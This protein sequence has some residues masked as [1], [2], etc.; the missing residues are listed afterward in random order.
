M[1]TLTQQA[2]DALDL[3]TYAEYMIDFVAEAQTDDHRVIAAEQ[4]GDGILITI[5]TYGRKRTETRMSFE[6]DGRVNRVGGNASVAKMLTDTVE[7]YRERCASY[8]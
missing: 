6:A 8:C 5:L 2:G 7:T 4:D 3:T 1:M